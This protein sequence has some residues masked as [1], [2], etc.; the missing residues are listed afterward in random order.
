MGKSKSYFLILISIIISLGIVVLTGIKN[1][2]NSN[3]SEVYKVYLDGDF[4]GAIRSRVALEKYINQE[5][6]DLKKEYDVKKVYIPNGIDIEKVITYKGKVLSEKA[7]YKKIK[8]KKSFTIKGYVVN[9]SKEDDKGK[10]NE[11]NLYLLNKNIFDE[12]VQNVLNSFV[13]EEDVENYKNDTQPEIKTTGSTIENIFIDQDV[14]IKEAFI[15][16]D[17]LIFTN[18]TDLTK[19]LLFG[20][21]AAGEEYTVKLGDTIETVAFNNKLSTKEFL[22]VNPEFTSSKNILSVGQKVSVALINPLLNIVVEK[23][24]VEDVDKP[25]E[26]IEKEDS[27]MD[28]GTQK[29]ETEGVNG[30][31]R[32]TE[33]IQYI[34]GQSQNA[35]VTNKVVLKE[36]VNKVVLKGTREVYTGSYSNYGTPAI[37]TGN[38]GWPTISPYVITSYFEYRWGRLHEGIDI[39][40]CGFGSPIYAAQEGTVLSTVSY[41]PNYGSLNDS[42]GDWFG[43]HVWIAHPDNVY[44]VYAHLVNVVLVS[45]GQHVSKGQVI[46]YMGDSGSSTGTHL[47]FGTF[48]GGTKYGNPGG[49]SPFNPYSLY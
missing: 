10:V 17:E 6:K 25:F 16:T 37:T 7:I 23:N 29:V 11:M 34:N 9:I 18:S 35:Y 31:Q 38:W 47:H 41:C 3:P 15:S 13:S 44:I 39:S 27:S 19:Y 42:C 22:I 30:I 45:P 5:Q 32:V 20:T 4:I 12:A 49:G 2:D 36:P 43:N 24:V 48:Y 40:G 26:T 21:L 14:T 28:K 33:K 1:T 8:Q 46:G